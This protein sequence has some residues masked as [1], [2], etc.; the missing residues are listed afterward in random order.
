MRYCKNCRKEIYDNF[1]FCNECGFEIKDNPN[2]ETIEKE[3]PEKN[4][5]SKWESFFNIFI[6]LII[7]SVARTSG[8]IFFAL[9]IPALLGTWFAKW[10]AKKDKT[11]YPLMR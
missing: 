7:I 6:F 1:N 5:T 9:V 3:I 11:T 10:Y 8:M 4:S 2:T